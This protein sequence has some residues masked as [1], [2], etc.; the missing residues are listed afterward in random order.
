MEKEPLW[1]E[2]DFILVF[3]LKLCKGFTKYF[4]KFFTKNYFF[5]TQ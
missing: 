5:V 4:E 1:R 2:S 3:I